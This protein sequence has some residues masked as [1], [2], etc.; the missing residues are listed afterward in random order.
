MNYLLPDVREYYAEV[1]VILEKLLG[2][3]GPELVS[4]VLEDLSQDSEEVQFVVEHDDPF[5]VALE[6]GKKAYKDWEKR[7][8]SYRNMRDSEDWMK[9]VRAFDRQHLS[10]FTLDEKREAAAQ[11]VAAHVSRNI[12]PTSEM[13]GLIQTV[14]QTL[15][16]LGQPEVVP[17]QKL[18]PAVSIRRSIEPDYLVCLEDGK[19]LKMLKRYL[20]ATYNLSP[21]E[22]RD[23]WGLPPDYPMVAPNYAQQR[24]R[25]AKEIGLGRGSSRRVARAKNRA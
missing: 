22:Y 16:N 2:E 25:L 4:R 15:S 9:A 20:R 24:S 1:G 21:D 17:S 18:T 11:I 13:P 6:I 12:V 23:K 19:K 10:K 5:Q 14:Y 8:E 7:Y 3:N